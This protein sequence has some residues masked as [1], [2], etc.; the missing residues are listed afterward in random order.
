MARACVAALLLS[1]HWSAAA[2][3]G[4]RIEKTL[5]ASPAA[6]KAVWGIRVVRAPSGEVIFERNSDQLFTPASNT[7]LF[8]AALALERLGPDYRFMT[9][10]TAGQPPDESGL[11]RGDLRL[12]GGGDPTMSAREI[13]Y[14]KGPI[15]GEPMRAI[16]ELAGEVAA[17][18]VRRIEGGIIGDDTRYPWEPFAEGWSQ[19]DLAW[20]Y[21]APVSALILNDNAISLTLR[22]GKALG[23]PATVRLS[24]PIEFYAIDN[25]VTTTARTEGKIAVA[26]LPGGRQVRLRGGVGFRDPGRTMRLAAHDPALFAA[27]ALYD[28]LVRRG[29]SIAGRAVA[30][31]RFPPGAADPPGDAG[32]R[33]SVELAVRVSPPLAEVLKIVHK[34]SQNLYAEL[35][36]REVGYAGGNGGGLDK[37]LDELRA[38]LAEA[39]IGEQEYE[40]HDGSGLSRLNLVSPA[41]VVKLLLRMRSSAHGQAW[42]ESLPA[43][44]EDG[45]LSERFQGMAGGAQIRAKTGTLAHVSALSGYAVS[46][47]GEE[48]A[49]SILANNYRSQASEIRALIDRIVMLMVQ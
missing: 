23:L 6:R 5:A 16:E 47:S 30:E 10:V 13:P 45:T 25:R 1:A 41:A 49:F 40:F 24:P 12:V 35:V 15:A 36:L 27:H 29:V 20:D 7:K 11:V 17:R 18:R 9:K 48:L 19:D 28:A 2:D 43:G 32:T 22:P 4:E 42:L 39:G 33:S 37:S 34:A 21:G 46:K 38:F 14:T 26:R 44:G 31:H 3:L 8:T